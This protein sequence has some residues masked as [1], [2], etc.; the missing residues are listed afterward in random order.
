MFP[1]FKTPQEAC[2][3]MNVSLDK[4][5]PPSG[6]HIRLMHKD[7]KTHDRSVYL[8]VFT[9]K[10]G[11]LYDFRTRETVFWISDK[12]ISKFNLNNRTVEKSK[13]NRELMK[14]LLRVATQ[15]QQHPYLERKHL[16]M[17]ANYPLYELRRKY[18][19]KL[20]NSWFMKHFQ[21]ERFILV[22]MQDSQ[23]N[24]Q[25]AQL[26]NEKGDKRFLTGST[27]NYF[28]TTHDLTNANVIGFAEGVATALS[29]AQIHGFPVV[30]TMSCSQFRNV[31]PIVKENYPQAKL[32]VLSDVGNGEQEARK[33]AWENSVRFASPRF[34]DEDIKKFE[35]LNQCRP[36]DFNDYFV[37]TGDLP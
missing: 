26:I 5:L 7:S 1:I 10:S 4:A 30:A 22:P 9:E 23:G 14:K 12:N 13:S 17:Y 35:K 27:K 33:V 34:T 11:C 21:G 32:I 2:D 28:F 8:N 19:E 29:V 6:G 24:I 20:Y 36:T 25:T 16:R 31:V 18:V 3:A 15:I 37:L